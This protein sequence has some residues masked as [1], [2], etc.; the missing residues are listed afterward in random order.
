MVSDS[1]QI[2]HLPDLTDWLDDFNTSFPAI[3]LAELIYPNGASTLKY[4][5]GRMKFDDCDY[6]VAN[7]S[8]SPTGNLARNEMYRIDDFVGYGA[9]TKI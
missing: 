2:S 7:S 9:I 5:A 3:E 6:F 1:N 4:V 8:K